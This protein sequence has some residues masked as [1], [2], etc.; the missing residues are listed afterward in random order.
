MIATQ[1]AVCETDSADREVYSASLGA[2]AATRERFSARRTP[3]RVH[4]RMVR[5]ENCGLLRS[6]PILS[7]DELARLYGESSM[8]YEE[9]LGFARRTYGRYLQRSIAAFSPNL[10]LSSARLLEIGCG[11][12]FFLEEAA[13]LGFGEVTGVEP[14]REAV[15]MAPPSIRGRIVNDIFRDDLFPREHFDVICAFQ[16]F[17]HLAH[18]NAVLKSC[19]TALRPGGVALF[20]NHDV[21]AWTNRFLGERSP[22]IDIE[23]IYLFDTQTMPRIFE[24]NGF[25]VLDVF[26]VENSYPLHYW[27]KMAPIP[28]G[29]KEKVIPALQQSSLGRREIAW[30]AGNLGLVARGAVNAKVAA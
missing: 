30:K 25:E 8:T 10:D 13:A 15:E 2:D 16:V 3:D 22:V 20:I 19:R 4:Y 26:P 12:G 29:W 27:M 21:G 23:H 18:P 7:D 17:D 5:C 11:N 14:S 24:K 1:C 28:A 6:N 9:E